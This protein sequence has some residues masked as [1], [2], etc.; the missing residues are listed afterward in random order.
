MKSGFCEK[1]GEKNSKPGERTTGQGVG[2][3]PGERG[4]APEGQELEKDPGKSEMLKMEGQY[5]I[6]EGSSVGRQKE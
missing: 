3:G 2:W 4:G 1:T 5:E 6:T